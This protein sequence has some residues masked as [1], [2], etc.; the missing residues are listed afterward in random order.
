MGMGGGVGVI[1]PLA[2]ELHDGGVI[3]TG[4]RT[5]HCCY[6]GGGGGGGGC[7]L[8]QQNHALTQHGGGGGGT[9]WLQNQALSLHEEDG[10]GGYILTGYR[11]KHCRN[12]SGGGGGGG[13]GVYSLARGPSTVRT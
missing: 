6:T 11:T 13:G 7:T 2:T 9:H 1:I 5:K 10:R 12:M 3:L 4:Y 8:W